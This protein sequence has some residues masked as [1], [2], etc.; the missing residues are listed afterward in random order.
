ML[1]QMAMLRKTTTKALFPS[2]FQPRISTQKWR[3]RASTIQKHRHHGGAICLSSSMA[4]VT[5]A[6]PPREPLCD[7]FT[8]GRID[9]VI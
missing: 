9:M 8:H 7:V 1:V 5:S 3:T 2:Y 4:M 6:T